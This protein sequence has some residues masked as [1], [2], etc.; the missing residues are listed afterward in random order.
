MKI[1]KHQLL[2]IKD[3]MTLTLLEIIKEP[4]SSFQASKQN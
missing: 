4:R 1:V 3:R 2:K